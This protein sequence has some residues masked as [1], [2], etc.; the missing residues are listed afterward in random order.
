[1]S[2]TTLAMA[3]RHVAELEQRIVQQKARIDGMARENRPKREADLALSSG[4]F[5]DQPAACPGASEVRAS[6][7]VADMSRLLHLQRRP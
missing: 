6:T 1:M 4:D 5:R 3:E 7:S 2:D